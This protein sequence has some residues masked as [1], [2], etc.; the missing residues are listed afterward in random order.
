MA[1][2][3]KDNTEPLDQALENTTK[4]VPHAFYH[5][6]EHYLIG[7]HAFQPGGLADVDSRKKTHAW[8]ASYLPPTG[9]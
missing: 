2:H 6:D 9:K 7:D 4:K 5:Y 3:T 1:R 8:F